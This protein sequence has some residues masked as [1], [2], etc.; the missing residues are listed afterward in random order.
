MSTLRTRQRSH[1]AP[2]TLRFSLLA[3]GFWLLTLTLILHQLLVVLPAYWSGIPAAY[4][5]GVRLKDQS[6][7]VPFYTP[8]SLLTN[9][10][11]FPALILIGFVAW[12]APVLAVL[13]GI[14]L[15]QAWRQ[16]PLGTKY[17][18]LATL[19]PLW[20]LTLLTKTA[21]YAFFIWLID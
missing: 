21:A 9:L 13:W 3:W 20:G 4:Q 5:A 19:L 11:L 1:P 15:V 7:A 14:L 18:W 8:Y 6:F 16:L 12:L 17:G 10:L 2:P